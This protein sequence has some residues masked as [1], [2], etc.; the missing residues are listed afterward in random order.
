V[1]DPTNKLTYADLNVGIPNLLTC[2]EMVPLSLFFFYAYPWRPYLLSEQQK[3][4]MNETG[5]SGVQFPGQYQGG[6]LG[7]WAWLGMFNPSEIVQAIAFAFSMMSEAR[8]R[9]R[10]GRNQ[11]EVNDGLLYSNQAYNMV[12]PSRQSQGTGAQYP[13]QQ[14]PQYPV[15]NPGQQ[16]D[17]RQG[18]GGSY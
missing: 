16:A 14:M 10:S 5:D 1:L 3:Q 11:G 6:P 2:L 7:V 4:F 12:P 18:A 9:G 15:P 17:Y 8:R 13:P